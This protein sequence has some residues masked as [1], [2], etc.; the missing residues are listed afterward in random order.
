MGLTAWAAK[1]ALRT[2]TCPVGCLV[3]AA[4]AF[5]LTGVAGATAE[6][7]AEPTADTGP[8]LPVLFIETRGE[9]AAGTAPNDGGG[10][11]T[12]LYG[13]T[14]TELTITPGD[15]TPPGKGEGASAMHPTRLPDW[16]RVVDTGD[17]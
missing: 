7:V 1:S 13:V 11:P 8:L 3:P 5:A 6:P 17:A 4:A 12:L 16:D 10:T 2:I 15:S 14:G 9:V